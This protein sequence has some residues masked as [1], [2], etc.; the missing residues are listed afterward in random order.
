[1]VARLLEFN[2]LFA[3]RI[4]AIVMDGKVSPG[5]DVICH[6]LASSL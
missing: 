5:Y 4:G 3:F 1:V 2:A 6:F